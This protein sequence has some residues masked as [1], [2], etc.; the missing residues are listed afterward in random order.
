M[1]RVVPIHDPDFWTGDFWPDLAWLRA[2][3]PV[4]RVETPAGPVWAISRH[5]DVLAIS[6][7]PATWRSGRGVLIDDLRRPVAGDESVI[8]LDPPD[9]ARHRKLVSGWFRPSTVRAF[10]DRVRE[11]AAGL[12]D[13]VP[14]GEV[15]DANEDLAIPLPIRVIADML[16]VPAADQQRFRE[17]SDQVIADGSSQEVG[18]DLSEA[19]VSLYVYFGEFLAARKEAPG[20]DLLSSLVEAEL[21]GERL[22]DHEMLAFCMTLL[23]AGNET[24][25]NLLANGLATLAEHPEQW[26][27]LVAD[28]GLVPSAVEEL[29]RWVTPVVHFGRTAT[30]DVEIAGQPIAEGE[31][32]V[33]L[34][35][36]AN[37]DESVFGPTAT[38]LDIGRDPNPHMAFGFG[39]HFCLGAQLAR[40]EARIFFEELLARFSGLSLTGP[41]RR[42]RGNLMRGLDALPMRFET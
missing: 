21:D 39:E 17:W 4:H 36:S 32:V 42:R 34:Y 33:M 22:S 11:L 40:L 24:T 19:V 12:L 2:E 7:D 20:D 6:R 29:L 25:R 41:V 8:Y 10:E 35:P 3:S 28:P 31:M 30:R 14:A 9:H 23:V 1:S 38:T 13:G 5:A 15:F 18:E 37:R 16:G 26:K 27:R